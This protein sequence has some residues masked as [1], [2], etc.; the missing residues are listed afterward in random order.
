MDRLGHEVRSELGR[1]APG[2]AGVAAVVEAW[3]RA[4]GETVAQRAWPARL[5]RDGTLLVHAVSSTWAFELDR[6]ADT[7]LERLRQELGGAAPAS[8][9]FVAG[10]VPEPLSAAAAGVPEPPRPLPEDVRLA[11]S[12]ASAIEDPE[13]RALVARAAAASLSRARAESGSDSRF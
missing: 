6:M 3:P 2:D 9:R 13:L 11:A 12:A 5:R 7:V 8:L 4:V 10:P 1:L